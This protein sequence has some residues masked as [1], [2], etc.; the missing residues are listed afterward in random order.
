MRSN[1]ILFWVAAAAC[2]VAHVAIVRSVMRSRQSRHS[3]AE[4]TWA[5]VPAIGLL[6]VFLW[7][8]HV[9]HAVP[10]A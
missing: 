7:T 1:L 10:P 4:A 5:V 9:L 3:A 8:W 2:L 6:A